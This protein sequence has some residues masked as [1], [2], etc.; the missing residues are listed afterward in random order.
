MKKITFAFTMLAIALT[1]CCTVMQGP[2]QAI[3]ISSN[4]SN[5]GIWIDQQYVGT[6]PVIL[7]LSRSDNHHIRI[8][9]E[10][11][12]PYEAVFS[13]KISGWVF[14]NIIFGGLIGLAVDALT[15]SIYVLTPEQVQ[16]EMQANHMIYSP[17]GTHESYIGVVLKPDA[18]WEKIGQ[19]KAKGGC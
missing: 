10:G 1:S 3:G 19:L 12:C 14:G 17:K 15:G 18:S 16:A 9:L 7:H 4:P 5:A 13:K 11:Y 8:E 2:K 6:T